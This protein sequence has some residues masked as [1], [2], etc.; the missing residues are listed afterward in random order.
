MQPTQNKS[1][2]DP[3]VKRLQSLLSKAQTFSVFLAERL[4]KPCAQDDATGE[5][6]LPEQPDGMTG[7]ILRAYQIEGLAWLISLYENGMNGILADEMGLGKTVMCIAFLQYLREMGIPGYFLIVAPLSV[8]QNWKEEFKKFVP[9]MEV[10]IYH[11]DKGTRE[12]L[13]R[14][15][16]PTVTHSSQS[17]SVVITSF[18]MALKDS[19][20]LGKYSW[21][22]LIVD[23]GHR[24][25]NMNCKLLKELKSLKTDN[26]L[27]LTGTPLQNNLIELWSLLNF[28][29]PEV[30]ENVDDFMNWFEFSTST[31][32]LDSPFLDEIEAQRVI[33][34]LHAI[35]KPLLLRRLKT[36]VEKELPPKREYIISMP[37]TDVQAKLYNS[38]LDGR[39]REFS[40]P[41][42]T[43]HLKSRV[44]RV[45][46]D[47]EEVS[48][49]FASCSL[50]MQNQIMQLR[51]VCNHPYLFFYP[52]KRSSTEM[53]VDR[54]ILE[55]SSKMII[56][57]QLLDNL[58]SSNHKVL[59]FCQM[60]KVLDILEGYIKVIR[61]GKYC[62]IDGSTPHDERLE[63][64]RL[65]NKD[66]KR[67]IFLLTTRAG[68]L[69]LNLVTADTVI[70]FD[71]DWVYH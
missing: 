29:L 4:R 38:I 68:G 18:E 65:F 26:R 69:G 46:Y 64:I 67:S 21:K 14:D 49:G 61:K 19:K 16:F 40:Y 41:G 36:D 45:E 11:G 42:L 13:R 58:L 33:T 51:K 10:C 25:K 66:S 43:E 70:F 6:F 2:A 8:I 31:E 27:L 3:E 55:S 9:S 53:K 23:E 35:L 1:M 60:A 17:V 37:L 28:L 5:V 30:F 63:Q 24:L 62:R 20:I 52:L 39:L 56:L 57:D 47:D 59:V 12:A 54:L 50:S 22:Y 71:S 44:N 15:R 32:N 7:G 48:D 34:Q